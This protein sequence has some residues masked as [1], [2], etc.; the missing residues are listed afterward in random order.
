MLLIWTV[1]IYKCKMRAVGTGS[2][3]DWGV[4]CFTSD[5]SWA[6]LFPRA[7]V[8]GQWSSTSI[9]KCAFQEKSYS[10]EGVGC[11]H[12]VGQYAIFTR[13]PQGINLDFWTFFMN[14]HHGLWTTLYKSIKSQ[15]ALS[16]N[17]TSTC[18]PHTAE[19]LQPHIRKGLPL[20]VGK[21]KGI[22]GQC[23]VQPWGPSLSVLLC[24]L[25]PCALLPGQILGCRTNPKEGPPGFC[26]QPLLSAHHPAGLPWLSG[27]PFM[28]GPL[29]AATLPA[30]C[31]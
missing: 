19:S 16:R 5:A 31:A 12:L 18:V 17:C 20:L 25:F 10:L 29:H 7:Q 26:P 13:E 6:G 23:S 14:Q 11:I 1:S 2:N 22:N 9:I 3:R 21:K 24:H 27:L 8:S 15:I 30:M 28:T 4:I